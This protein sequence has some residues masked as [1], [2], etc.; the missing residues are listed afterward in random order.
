MGHGEGGFMPYGF[1]NT[2]QGAATCFFAFV[3]FDTIA[4]LGESLFFILFSAFI[5]LVSTI[6][7]FI[8][9]FYLSRKQKSANAILTGFFFGGGNKFRMKKRSVMGK[10]VKYFQTFIFITHRKLFENFVLLVFE[11]RKTIYTVWL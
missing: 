6:F 11:I 8:F 4:C 2:M 10:L 7:H 1:S 3:G 5:F 9:C